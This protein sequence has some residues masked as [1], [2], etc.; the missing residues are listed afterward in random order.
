MN[1]DVIKVSTVNTEVYERL[2]HQISTG[3][4]PPGQK[5]TIREIASKFGVSTMP[6]REGIRRLQA[7]GLLHFERRSVVVRK[8]SLE[9]VKQIFAIR[10]RLET[11][12]LEWAI[13][14]IT[15]NDIQDLAKILEEMNR[16]NISYI[17]WQQ[18]NRKF[19][20]SIYQYSNS[21]SLQK[22][23]INIWDSVTPYMCIYSSTISS[24]KASQ[25]EHLSILKLIEEKNLEE[26]FKV[27][28]Q[29]L[30]QTREAIISA[31]KK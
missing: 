6:V 21:K 15:K 22:L 12:A 27:L 28:D 26:L 5:I 19:H 4:I 13:Q 16:K 9:E 14:N 23:I 25:L 10:Y 30:N 29:H 31:L 3:E 7:E 8:L 17:E 24:Y 2:R 20:T 18:L 1:N 11:L